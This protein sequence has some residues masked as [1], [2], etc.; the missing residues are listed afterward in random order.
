MWITEPIANVDSSTLA[1]AVGYY[2]AHDADFRVH[3]DARYLDR[4]PLHRALLKRLVLRALGPLVG[5]EF[6]LWP[7]QAV[8][9][10]F[11]RRMGDGA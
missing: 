4:M 5:R 11:M 2:Y 10:E 9:A 8:L 6:A 1:K 3:F 7:P